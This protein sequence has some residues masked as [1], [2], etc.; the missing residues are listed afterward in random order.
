[1]EDFEFS[2]LETNE[3]LEDANEKGKKNPASQTEKK[4]KRDEARKVWGQEV[5]ESDLKALEETYNALASEY[6]GSITPRLAMNL[7]DIA[8]LRLARD[9]ALKNGETKEAVQYAGMIDKIMTSEAL[10]A[11]DAKP[12]EA[13]RPDALIDRLEKLGVMSE[14]AMFDRQGIIDYINA[15]KGCYH[16]SLDVVDEMMLLIENSRRRNNGETEIDTLPVG[17]QVQDQF[18]ELKP[19]MTREEQRNMRELGL[20]PPPRDGA[21]LSYAD[22][23]DME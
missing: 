12:I 18:H 13:F 6:K 21:G 23:K 14:G 17:L 20:I 4:I 2:S 16:T 3:E 10:K 9:K 1:M 19:E 8:K 15:D 22:R 7:R 11:G 5:S